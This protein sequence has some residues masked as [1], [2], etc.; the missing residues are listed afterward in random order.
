MNAGLYTSAGYTMIDLTITVCH[1]SQTAGGLRIGGL[2]TVGYNT[3]DLVFQA[4]TTTMLT[5]NHSQT[6]QETM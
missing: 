5:V 3:G 1:S 6:C 2:S 4:Q